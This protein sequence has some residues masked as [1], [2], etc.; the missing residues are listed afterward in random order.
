LRTADSVPFRHI[1]DTAR[2]VAYL[3]AVE[4]ERA[5]A[6]FH[7]AHARELAAMDAS[8]EAAFVAMTRKSRFDSRTMAVRTVAIDRMIE[9][10]VLDGS[11]DTVLN[12]AAGLDTRPFRMD[13]PKSLRWV[14]V[15]LPGILEHKEKILA[16]EAP[17][18]QR[19]VLRA[20]LADDGVRR[21]LL[22]DIAASRGKI[23]VLTEG[24]LMYL[25][26]EA[27]ASL[28]RDL[29]THPAYR[30]WVADMLSPTELKWIE[31]K[32]GQQMRAA[33]SAVH[34]ACG[35]P[36]E[37]FGELGWR[38]VEFH[39][40]VELAPKMHRAGL[41]VH[42]TNFASRLFPQAGRGYGFL[43]LERAHDV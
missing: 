14:E 19:E 32:W 30:Y 35:N 4:S 26:P 12:L 39:S 5:D 2:F 25:R 34:F 9:A 23:L 37:Y 6:L 1:S 22:A 31:R 33:N 29:H 15:D 40:H 3:R 18:C 27:V 7:D 24:L 21:G 43:V 36:D 13:L 41:R 28:G 17:R 8:G 10:R 20:D 42:L 38:L 16:R 11:V